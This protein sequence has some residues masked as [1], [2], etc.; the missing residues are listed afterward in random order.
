[1]DISSPHQVLVQY[2]VFQSPETRERVYPDVI[3]LSPGE[4][5]HPFAQWDCVA[6][7]MAYVPLAQQ[8]FVP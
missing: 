2:E 1:M 7:K 8:G 5:L 4:E 6:R 3:E